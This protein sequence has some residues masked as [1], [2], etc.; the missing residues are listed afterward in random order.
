LFLRIAACRAA[1]MVRSR[2]AHV[3]WCRV[4]H[5]ERVDLARW[6]VLAALQAADLVMA[7]T[8]GPAARAL[9]SRLYRPGD[10]GVSVVPGLRVGRRRPDLQGSGKLRP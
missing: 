3:G 6:A 9:F 4:G 2:G 7:G 1:R 10:A 5:W 8:P